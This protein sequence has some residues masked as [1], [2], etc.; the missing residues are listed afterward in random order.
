MMSRIVYDGKDRQVLPEKLNLCINP[1][2]PEEHPLQL[3]NIV[4]GGSIQKL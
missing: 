3:V 1:L 2:I 4:T